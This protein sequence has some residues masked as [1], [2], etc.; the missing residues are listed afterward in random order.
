MP[1]LAPTREDTDAAINNWHPPSTEM[2]VSYA[3]RNAH[4]DWPRVRIIFPIPGRQERA[5]FRRQFLWHL[6]F[7]SKLVGTC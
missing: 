1:V 7:R 5:Q 4:R 2:G 3:S 6:A